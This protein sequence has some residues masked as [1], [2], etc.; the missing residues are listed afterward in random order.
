LN[1]IM[2]EYL[3]VLQEIV[4]RKNRILG[5][6]IKAVS[7]ITQF[8]APSA[9]DFED[10]DD[11]DDEDYDTM[12]ADLRTRQEN[13]LKDQEQQRT[14]RNEDQEKEDHEDEDTTSD[15]VRKRP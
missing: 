15:E 13:Y 1:E 7:K 4:M 6:S 14:T 5:A 11:E 8:R 3:N 2:N 9:S 12:I 10:D